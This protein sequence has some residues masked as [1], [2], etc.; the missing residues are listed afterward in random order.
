MQIEIEVDNIYARVTNSSEPNIDDI[1]YGELKYRPEGYEHVWS[2]QSER[3]D[4]FNRLYN[5]QTKQFRRGLLA[6]VVETCQAQFGI[7]PYIKYNLKENDTVLHKFNSQLIRPY[8]FQQNI[9][10]VVD[11]EDVG[12]IVSPTGSGKSTMI[13][14]M[15][16]RLSRVTM[17]LVT[18]VVLLDQ[19]QQNLQRL[20]DQPIGMIGDGEFDLQ[21]I[22]VS[23]LQS[24]LSITNAKSIGSAEKRKHLTKH[25]NRVGLVISD[26][27]HLY[28]SESVGKVMPYFTHADKF[29]GTSAT[30]YGWASVAEKRQNLELE[31]HFGEVIYDCRKND[32]VQLGLKAPL[33]V[34]IFHQ[35]PLNKE[36]SKH[37]KGIG[38]GRSHRMVP[39]HTK[40]YR[41]ALETEILTNQA[42]HSAVAAMA[43]DRVC[44]GK[45][46]FV[47]APHRL[48][49][50]DRIAAQIPGSVIVNG[51]TP[52]LKRREI[53]DAMRK[54]ELLALV[55]DVGGTGLDI[56]SL[57]SLLL[58]GDTKDIRQLKGRV[59]RAAPN[60]PHGMLMDTSF[61]TSYLA[62]HA[63]IRR[64][65]YEHDRNIII[66]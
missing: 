45:S 38:H 62:K 21:D 35:M 50:S 61:N 49:F 28:D 51:S 43:W 23:T 65:Q 7:K 52:R 59:E 30:P 22:T 34:S 27:A 37:K 58:A 42:Y 33:L 8:D 54:K 5:R 63:E 4:G 6:R 66:G 31:Q 12:I 53:Y 20:F 60:K 1:L 47:H 32:F 36:Y 18:D 64:S 19:M 26:E 44:H 16:E 10:K 15:I 55:S 48:D 46:V 11:G 17:I 13:A 40:N 29:Y 3:W 14:L 2:F 57:D 24:M 39:D 25:F 56:P 41:E 9:K